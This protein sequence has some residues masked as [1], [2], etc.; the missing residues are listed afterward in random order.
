MNK[1]WIQELT[2]L[3]AKGQREINAAYVKRVTAAKEGR[4]K[5]WT[6]KAIKEAVAEAEQT[7][8]GIQLDRMKRVMDKK[9]EIDK[10]I[11][12]NQD[13]AARTY[14]LSKAAMLGQG[15]DPA[16]LVNLYRQLM[17]DS[18]AR[19][20]KSEYETVI[21][22]ALEGS[23]YIADFLDAKR[24]FM[25]EDEKNQEQ[26]RVFLQTMAKHMQTLSG[27]E[28]EKLEQIKAG[29]YE[30]EGKDGEHMEFYEKMVQNAIEN[31][32]KVHP[33]ER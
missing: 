17:G 21:G 33:K 22:T 29:R 1:N 6:E 23:D 13:H 5:E 26:H 3:A 31:G 30:G 32:E 25:T 8:K 16:N 9:A 10:M 2:A 19:D 4:S 28:T 14:H 20:H 7:L 24:Q 27:L 18:E 11:E 12:K 15:M